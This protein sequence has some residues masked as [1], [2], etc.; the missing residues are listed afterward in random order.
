MPRPEC[1]VRDLAATFP[2]QAG[3]VVEALPA[4]AVARL[5]PELTTATSNATHILEILGGGE[6]RYEMLVWKNVFVRP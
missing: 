3:R 4:P 6:A 5:R 2:G 1:W